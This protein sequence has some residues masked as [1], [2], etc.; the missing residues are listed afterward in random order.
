[1]NASSRALIA[2]MQ[3]VVLAVIAGQ[4]MAADE[5]LIA[6]NRDGN[7]EIY[8]V[9]LDDKGQVTKRAPQNLSN[10]PGDDS[11]PTWSPDGKRIAFTSTRSGQ[12]EIHVVDAGG[13][14]VRQ[15]TKHQGLYPYC[16]DW[17]PNGRRIVY[18]L[19]YPERIVA[20]LLD[21]DTGNHRPLIE[22][23]WDPDWSPDGKKIAYTKF[24]PDG[25]KIHVI[26]SDW[27]NETDLDT[28]VNHR[29]WAYPAWSPDGKRLAFANQVGEDI[30]LFVCD[31]DGKNETRITN[32]GGLNSYA[33]WFPDGKRILF[34]QTNQDSQVW[35]YYIVNVET[36]NLEV[37]EELKDEPALAN[38]LNPGR[39]AFRLKKLAA[40]VER[41]GG[42]RED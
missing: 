41:T 14:N 34:R 18:N 40:E 6:S 8:L 27:L 17:S 16:A 25:Y 10:D 36:L 31:A 1:M 7:A 4:V 22:N 37:I 24:T 42:N 39:S 33:A 29:G 13:K 38:N 21:P 15:M 11:Y 3:L 32:L 28:E 2:V 12:A 5:V 35:P 26:D 19:R 20:V 23:V 9:E 30:E